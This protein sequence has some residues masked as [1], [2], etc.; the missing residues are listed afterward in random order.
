[1]CWHIHMAFKWEITWNTGP[2]V[3]SQPPYVLWWVQR[4]QKLVAAVTA[5]EKGLVQH[6]LKIT[7]GGGEEDKSYEQP[8]RYLDTYLPL[9]SGTPLRSE[10]WVLLNDLQPLAEK[11]K[12]KKLHQSKY[13]PALSCEINLVWVKLSG[14]EDL[15]VG[16]FWAMQEA[17][18][19][20]LPYWKDV[21]RLHVLQ[22]EDEWIQ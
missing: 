20:F 16:R 13:M 11:K 12:I 1:M 7:A 15:H 17:H 2:R 14:T 4:V 5:G 10:T 19:D 3:G 6:R 18:V 9:K 21:W 8:P 22:Q